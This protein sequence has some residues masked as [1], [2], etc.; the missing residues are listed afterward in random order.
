MN[1]GIDWFT[2]LHYSDQIVNNSIIFK[3]KHSD[4]TNCYHRIQFDAFVNKYNIVQGVPINM[5]IQ[6]RIPYRIRLFK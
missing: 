1:G 6:W 2:D 4:I 5:G 3:I